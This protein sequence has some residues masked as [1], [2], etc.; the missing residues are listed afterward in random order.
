MLER[1]LHLL[2]R[3]TNHRSKSNVKPIVGVR[4]P[5]EIEHSEDALSISPAQPTPYL[6][7]EDSCAL[8]G[9]KQKDRVN[10]RNVDTFVKDVDGK[11][12]PQFPTAKPTH[13]LSTIVG[14]RFPIK[15]RRRQPCRV[16]LICHE[17]CV[18]NSD[19][20]SEGSHFSWIEYPLANSANDS[21]SADMIP[22]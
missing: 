10:L 17:S 20:K 9:P 13:R 16:E 15:S 14:V 12:G 19:A 7:Q 21:L 18:M 4:L 8:G 3:A 22:G 6:L 11:D 2:P 5:N 1:S